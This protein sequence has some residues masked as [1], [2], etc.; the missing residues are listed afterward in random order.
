MKKEKEEEKK[1]LQE[2]EYHKP[3]LTKHTKLTDIT[4]GGT[5]VPPNPA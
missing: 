4:A 5:Y 2:R 1:A 3:V